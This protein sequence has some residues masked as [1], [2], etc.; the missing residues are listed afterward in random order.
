MTQITINYHKYNNQLAICQIELPNENV[1]ELQLHF[2]RFLG[3][4]LNQGTI[5]QNGERTTIQF[6]ASK[7]KIQTLEKVIRITKEVT[8]RLN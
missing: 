8:A 2:Q 7:A 4:E 6:Q 1:T 3:Q 5:V